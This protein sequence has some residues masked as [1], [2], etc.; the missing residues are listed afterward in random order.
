[1]YSYLTGAASWLLYTMV[2][3]V[4]GVKGYLGDLMLEPKLVKNQFDLKNVASVVT[5]F[6]DKRL[7]VTYKNEKFLQYGEYNITK[8]L[9][10]SKIIT[11]VKSKN[12]EIIDKNVIDELSAGDEHQIY[13]E[14]E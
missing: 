11:T 14:L 13:I 10:D 1:M 8:I 2:S 5:I 9:L 6:R 3:E 7:N 4:Y 12:A